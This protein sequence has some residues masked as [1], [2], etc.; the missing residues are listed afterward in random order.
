MF[1][2]PLAHAW[3]DRRGAWAAALRVRLADL[4]AGTLAVVVPLAMWMVLSAGLQP[5]VDPLIK[6]P[7]ES[8]RP[9]HSV[10]WGAAA[11]LTDGFVAVTVPA[12]L[13]WSP[14]ALLPL[15][16]RLVGGAD[17]GRHLVTLLLFGAASI[18]SIWYFPHL[19][20]IAFIVPIFLVC[21][22]QT[23][24]DPLADFITS[25]YKSAQVQAIMDAGELPAFWLY[26]R[27]AGV[28]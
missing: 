13:R 25:H 8:Y 23:V 1:T 18:W 15:L 5:I 14:L 19:I 28:E 2:Y 17:S 16:L 24:E 4:A 11:P 10:R 9:G 26:R 3:L 6:F 22:A 20:H 12:L 21:A 27:K 7:V